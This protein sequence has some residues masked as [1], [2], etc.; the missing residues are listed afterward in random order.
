MPPG[1]GRRLQICDKIQVHWSSSVSHLSQISQIQRAVQGSKPHT[2]I[3]RSLNPRQVLAHDYIS[4]LI[5]VD[6][7]MPGCMPILVGCMAWLRVSS[8]LCVNCLIETRPCF[9]S[10]R[11]DSDHVFNSDRGIPTH[12]LFVSLLEQDTGEILVQTTKRAHKCYVGASPCVYVV[13]TVRLVRDASQEHT[14]T[15]EDAMF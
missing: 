9:T 7:C 14:I 6:S 2:E 12:A 4:E 1:S 5:I 15:L 8:P 10:V 13:A 3:Q 11:D